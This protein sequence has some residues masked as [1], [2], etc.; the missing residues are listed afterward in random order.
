MDGDFRCVG[1]GAAL[2]DL[3]AF[4]PRCGLAVGTGAAGGGVQPQGGPNY[5]PP[6]GW[7]ATEPNQLQSNVVGPA[8][9]AAPEQASSAP[10]WQHPAELPPAA[11]KPGST[12][13]RA[14]T[15]AGVSLALLAGCVFGVNW[16]LGKPDRDYIAALEASGDISQFSSQAE[17]IAKGKAVCDRL[18]TGSEA[19]GSAAELAATQAYCSEFSEG[20]HVLETK[21]FTGAFTLID[22][23]Y[24]RYYHG[25]LAYGGSCEGGN[26]Y[27]DIKAGTTVTVKNGDGTLLASSQLS[28]GSGTE[29][30]C[31]F[32]FDVTLTEGEDDYVLSISHRGEMHY[33]WESLTTD[34]IGVSLGS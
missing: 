29:S 28:A 10:E 14:L 13:L 30:R 18:E 27:S 32:D 9:S 11:P 2:P 16:W 33:T 20:F 23:S 6:Q 24:S 34:G 22:T 17:A 31:V 12:G 4:C 7:A 19:K 21:D 8:G 3:A 26:G 5:L 25:I 1:C 15:V